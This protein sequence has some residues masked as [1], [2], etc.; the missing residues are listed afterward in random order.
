MSLINIGFGKVINQSDVVAIIS[1][2]SA[3]IKRLIDNAREDNLLEDY[4]QNRKVRSVITMQ[5]KK[6]VLSALQPET[7]G[8]R[9]A[10]GIKGFIENLE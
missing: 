1:P 7:I 10:S 3:P 6:I 5:D 8:R 2:D 9:A 4:A